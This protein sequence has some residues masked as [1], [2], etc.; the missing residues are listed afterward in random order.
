[1]EQEL[2]TSDEIIEAFTTI[3]NDV[4]FEDLHSM[5]SECIQRVTWVIEHGESIIVN[6]CYSFLKE[7]SLV[8]K[9]RGVRIPGA[10]S[11]TCQMATGISDSVRW[12]WSGTGAKMESQRSV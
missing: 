10:F 12:S 3:W 2:S 8:E 1:M 7:F 4:T 5:F 9:S 11:R 6:Y